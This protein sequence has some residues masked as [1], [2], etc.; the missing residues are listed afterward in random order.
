[1]L[2]LTRLH[3]NILSGLQHL[4]LFS[5]GIKLIFEKSI[6]TGWIRFAWYWYW[7]YVSVRW[8]VLNHSAVLNMSFDLSHEVGLSD[9]ICGKL[10]WCLHRNSAKP[11]GLWKPPPNQGYYAALT[12]NLLSI[13]A[14]EREYKW[15]T[16]VQFRF[17]MYSTLVW[18]STKP[19]WL[20]LK[21][22]WSTLNMS[23]SLYGQGGFW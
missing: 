22:G 10:V 16:H 12:F 2:S 17:Y 8:T 20:L 7:T 11:S 4:I 15:Y 14:S 19:H 6:L 18:G 5:S 13:Y 21:S 23:I 3:E 1:M 9:V